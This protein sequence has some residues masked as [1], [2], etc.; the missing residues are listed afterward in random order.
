MRDLRRLL[1]PELGSGAGGTDEK[2]DERELME[3]G[4]EYNQQR[5]HSKQYFSELLDSCRKCRNR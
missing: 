5:L 3:V 1:L 4:A 2:S